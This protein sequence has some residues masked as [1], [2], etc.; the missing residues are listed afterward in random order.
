MTP[1]FGVYLVT[2]AGLSGDR[3]T[4]EIVEAAVAGGVD[5]VQLREKGTTARER[6]ELG[7]DSAR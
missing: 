7:T 5:V 3:S 1:N 6:Y 4:P 2:D